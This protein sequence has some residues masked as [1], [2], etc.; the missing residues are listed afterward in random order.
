MRTFLRNTILNS[1]GSFKTIGSGVHILN[2]HYIGRDNLSQEIFHELLNKIGKQAD[3]V[4]FED[5]VELIS[6]KQTHNKKCVAFTFDDG[7]EE[8]Y[9]KI[10]PVLKDFNTNAAFFINPG[11]IDG[12]NDYINNFQQ[13]K[14][15]VKKQPMSWEQIK[16]LHQ[17]GFVIGNHTYDHIKLVEITS[18]EIKR[19]IISSKQKIEDELNS[20]C[21]NFAW[22]Y[23]G[24]N[25]INKDALNVALLEHQHVFSCDNYTKYHSNDNTQ[26][27][28]RRHIEGDWPISHV[29]YFLSKGKSY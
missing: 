20:P 29:K 4:K 19:Q 22:T 9:S 12:D 1:I 13:N 6:K 28:N 3:F 5:A 15:H 17:Q 7:F 16:E 2:S 8:C 18:D 24:M 14:V 27:I 25:D 10:A 26:I 23:G 21:N 11:F